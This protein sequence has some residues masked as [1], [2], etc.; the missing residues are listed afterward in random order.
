MQL[1]TS[2]GLHKHP[3]LMLVPSFQWVMILFPS[4]LFFDIDDCCKFR[5]TD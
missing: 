5:I 3:Q 2:V 1:F 4:L